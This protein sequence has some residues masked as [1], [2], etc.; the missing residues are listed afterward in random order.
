MDE[1]KLILWRINTKFL[2]LCQSK[3]ATTQEFLYYWWIASNWTPA[4]FRGMHFSLPQWTRH[5]S[6]TSARTHALARQENA[7]GKRSKLAGMKVRGAKRRG[8]RRVGAGDVE[9]REDGEERRRKEVHLTHSSAYDSALCI[10]ASSTAAAQVY[11]SKDNLRW[12]A[13]TTH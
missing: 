1:N 3:A 2:L 4:P 6:H 9:A 5:I 12:G 10:S 8:S 11:H 7:D 13:H